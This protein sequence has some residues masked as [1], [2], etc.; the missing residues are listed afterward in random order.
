MDITGQFCVSGDNA[1]PILKPS[2]VEDGFQSDDGEDSQ[3]GT[4][5]DRTFDI[6]SIS[7]ASLAEASAIARK[8]LQLTQSVF[9]IWL[10]TM[11]VDL[12]KGWNGKWYFLQVHSV[13][14]CG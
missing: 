14:I 6:F 3:T 2:G 4:I 13:T 9:K 10:D 8:V 7:G 5:T 1:P 12:I 11:V